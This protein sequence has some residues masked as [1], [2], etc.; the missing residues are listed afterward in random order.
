M[1]MHNIQILTGAEVNSEKLCPK[2]VKCCP[3]AEELY[4]YTLFSLLNTKTITN[5]FFCIVFY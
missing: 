5:R 3:R 2:V 4:F 1:S